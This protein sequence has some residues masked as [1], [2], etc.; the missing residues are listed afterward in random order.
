M[1]LSSVNDLPCDF[2]LVVIEVLL[3][4]I[5]VDGV[6]DWLL[7]LSWGHGYASRGDGEVAAAR[8]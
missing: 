2:D 6:N 4:L 7:A 8:S 3:D 5:L 1:E